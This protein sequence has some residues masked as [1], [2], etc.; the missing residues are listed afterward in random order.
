MRKVSDLRAERNECYGHL[1]PELTGAPQ[2]GV[3]FAYAKG[4]TD[5]VR[6]YGAHGYAADTESLTPRL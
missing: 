6:P 2:A 3:A 1:T 4:V 5:K